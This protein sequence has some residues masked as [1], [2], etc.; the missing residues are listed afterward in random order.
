[1]SK[2]SKIILEGFY[3]VAK[4]SNGKPVQLVKRIERKTKVSLRFDDCDLDS[5]YTFLNNF[6]KELI[7]P[8]ETAKVVKRKLDRVASINNLTMRKSNIAIMQA[9]QI[10]N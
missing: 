2:E 3:C 1:M 10:F 7:M 4:L 6:H 8:L 9:H 5:K